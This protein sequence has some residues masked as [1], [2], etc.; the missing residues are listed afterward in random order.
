MWCCHFIVHVVTLCWF[1]LV[2]PL[3]TEMLHEDKTYKRSPQLIIK[4][5]NI[6]ENTIAMN[7]G[8]IAKDR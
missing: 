8:Q 2:T 7:L 6:L 3:T 4:S 1:V 5:I